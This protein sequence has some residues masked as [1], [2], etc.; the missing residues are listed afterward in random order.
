MS[1]TVSAN[2]LRLALFSDTY[3]PQMNGVARTLERLVRTIRDRGGEVQIFTTTDP[4]AVGDHRV[5]RYPSAPFWAYPQLRL[6][7]PSRQSVLRQLVEF[8]P[9][10]I[11]AATP[12]GMGLA[13]R[14]AAGMLELPFVTSYHTS[15]SAYAQYYHLGALSTPG[16]AFLRWFHNSGLRTYVPSRA[17]GDE[18]ETRAFNNIAVWGRGVDTTHFSPAFRS[19][20]QRGSIGATD[21]TIVVGYVGRLALEKGIDVAIRAI[22]LV[23]ARAERPVR[24]VFVG[25]GPYEHQCRTAHLPNTVFLGRRMG[26]A[27]SEAYASMDMFIFP[28]TT[29][30]FGNVLVEAAASRLAIVA[31]DAGPTR[32][33]LGDHAATLFTPG[34]PDALAA[35]LVTAIHDDRARLALADA[36][37]ALAR[38]RS[39]D[40]IFDALID[41]YQRVAIPSPR[42]TTRS[43][44]PASRPQRQLASRT[45]P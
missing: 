18:L 10:L 11:H 30:T 3:G 27:L 39:W 14:W 32:E 42:L 13:A 36:A 9:T 25:D 20:T 22:P 6:A 35:A 45:L 21:D 1:M 33:L 7:A 17:I 28:S 24:F 26:Q 16:W 29:D 5:H 23:I 19:R 44:T 34:S 2:G 8:R 12:F 38:Q 43:R 41:D 15:F 40:A 4:E 31:A 37:L